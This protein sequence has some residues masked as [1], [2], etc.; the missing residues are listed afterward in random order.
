MCRGRRVTEVHDRFPAVKGI[1]G[2]MYLA[3]WN[4][5]AGEFVYV[6]DC[7]DPTVDAFRY[8][9]IDEREEILSGHAAGVK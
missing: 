6:V 3:H 1:T 7:L 8:P 9:G 5:R 2:V 4:E